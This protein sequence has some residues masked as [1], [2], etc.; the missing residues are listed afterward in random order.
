MRFKLNFFSN[1]ETNM[2][3]LRYSEGIFHLITTRGEIVE[4]SEDEIYNIF[5]RYIKER[6]HTK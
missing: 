6:N 2:Y 1:D 3:S 5:D 4:I